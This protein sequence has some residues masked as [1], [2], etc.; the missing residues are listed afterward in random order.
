LGLDNL[1]IT[2]VN[3]ALERGRR[4]EVAGVFVLKKLRIDAN[5]RADGALQVGDAEPFL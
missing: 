2:A 3:I 4:V 5:G 1:Q